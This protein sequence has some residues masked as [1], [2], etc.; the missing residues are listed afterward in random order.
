MVEGRYSSFKNAAKQRQIEC[1]MSIEHYEEYFYQQPCF[2]CGTVSNGID[3]V[4]S[5]KGYI[6]ENCLPCCTPCNLAKHTQTFNDFID[7]IKRIHIHLS[8]QHQTRRSNLAVKLCSP[9]CK[10]F[11][12]S[13]RG[14]P[15]DN[16][17]PMSL[18]RER[19]KILTTN[20][21]RQEF[22]FSVR[23]T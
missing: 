4:N 22:D 17:R 11:T 14:G 5:S 12:P 13:G 10:D 9:S 23:A 1:E 8:K 21:L 6:D 2:Y 18:N 19:G 20:R 7:H 3:R 15:C 16:F